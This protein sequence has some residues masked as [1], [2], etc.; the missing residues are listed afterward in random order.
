MTE[1]GI[2][3]CKWNEPYDNKYGYCRYT[4]LEKRNIVL[5]FRLAADMGKGTIVMVEC[6][7]MEL[8]E[9]KDAA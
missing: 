3:S 1:C 8:P 7:Q 5:K 6:L 9:E 4:E 2:I